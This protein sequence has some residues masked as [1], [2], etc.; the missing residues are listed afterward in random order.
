MLLFFLGLHTHTGSIQFAAFKKKN[1][2]TKQLRCKYFVTSQ[3][4]HILTSRRPLL[5]AW[6]S[7]GRTVRLPAW[8]YWACRRRRRRIET[9][10]EVEV[11]SLSKRS[12]VKKVYTV[13]GQRSRWRRLLFH[14]PVFCHFLADFVCARKHFLFLFICLFVLFIFVCLFFCEFYLTGQLSFYDTSW[15]FDFRDLSSRRRCFFYD[16]KDNSDVHI[17]TV[18]FSPPTSVSSEEE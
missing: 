3:N 1:T 15:L 14:E 2:K 9:M 13:G 5:V 10:A 16:I 8:C 12:N 18:I 11:W 17:G 6:G 7:A 4:T